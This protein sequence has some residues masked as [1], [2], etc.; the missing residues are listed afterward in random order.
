MIIKEISFITAPTSVNPE[1][2]IGFKG[3]IFLLVYN[4]LY[5]SSES[6]AA[7]CKGTG[8]AEIVGTNTG[9]DGTVNEQAH[10]KPDIFVETTYN[11]F[12]EGK[13]TVLNKA[14]ELCK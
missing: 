4:A 11:D 14:V 10:T 9:G 7:F 3:K 13:N 1:N 5:S 8:F 2:S 12:L 6:F